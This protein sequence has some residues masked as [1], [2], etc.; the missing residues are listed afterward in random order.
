MASLFAIFFME[1]A[2]YIQLIRTNL[3][4]FL[5]SC[6]PS[7]VVF[8]Q[9]FSSLT[10]CLSSKVMFHQMFLSIIGCLHSKIIFHQSLY[11]IRVCLG[12]PCAPLSKA[13]G[14]YYELSQYHP[15]QYQ[16]LIC[17]FLYFS[18]DCLNLFTEFCIS[19]LT[20]CLIFSW[21]ISSLCFV[22]TRELRLPSG[23][24]LTQGGLLH[25]GVSWS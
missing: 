1:V 22:S 15:A 16:G 20:N 13:L 18:L 9:M 24:S 7:K 17:F 11:S 25:Q 2:P 5:K 3:L 12:C 21:T 4:L 19:S 14:M 6:L 8:H 10:G 23:L